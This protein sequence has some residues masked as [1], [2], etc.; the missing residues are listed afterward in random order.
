MTTSK[1]G[2]SY[3]CLRRFEREGRT[4]LDFHL[5]APASPVDLGM[6]SDARRLGL[7]LRSLALGEADH[8]VQPRQPVGFG[9]GTDGERLLAGGWSLA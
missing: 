7:H 6:S 5:D 9:E 3:V 2:S 4:V 8:S 1:V